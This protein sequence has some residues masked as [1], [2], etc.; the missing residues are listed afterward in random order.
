MS[1]PA[2]LT[3]FGRT[4]RDFANALDAQWPGWREFA[5]N[6]PD[7][8]PEPPYQGCH[9]LCAVAHGGLGLCAGEAES[10]LFTTGWLDGMRIDIPVCRA[11]YQA[12][13]LAT[14]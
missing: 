10:D 1:T 11:C 12:K 7:Y 5:A 8:V 3:A 2:T 13:V 9:C 4:C 14:T 6:V